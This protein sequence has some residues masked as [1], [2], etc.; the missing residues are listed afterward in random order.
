MLLDTT[1]AALPLVML[2]IAQL[3]AGFRSTRTIIREL[4]AKRRMRQGESAGK[5]RRPGAV[6][7]GRPSR[8][9]PSSIEIVLTLLGTTSILFTIVD[10]FATALVIGGGAEPQSGILADRARRLA[11]RVHPPR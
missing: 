4:P 6:R 5:H 1:A 3:G 2:G 11:L 7:P 8:A 9:I 10:V